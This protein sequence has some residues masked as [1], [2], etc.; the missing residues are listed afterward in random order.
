MK[1]KV[2]SMKKKKDWQTK[3]MKRKHKEHDKGILGIMFIMKHFFRHLTEW[4]EEMADPRNVSYITYSQSDY[5]YL[6]ILKNLCGVKTMHSMEEQFNEEACICTLGILS[7]NAKSTEIPHSDSLNNYLKKLSPDCLAELRKKMIKSLLRMKT[8]YGNR[9]LGKYWRIIIDGTSLYYFKEK[10]CENCLVTTRTMKNGKTL[11]LY[12]HK[13][14]EAKL[15]L[16]SKIVLSIDTEFVENESENTGK[17]D[18]E[19]NAAKRMLARLKQNYPHLPICIQ[20][21][22]LYETE[23]VIKLCKQYGF[24]YLLTHKGSRQKLLEESYRLFVENKEAGTADKIC[25]EKGKAVYV[26]HIERTVEKEYDANI[27]GYSYSEKK[28]DGEIKETKFQWIT[29]IELNAKNLE[30][31]I[32]TGRGRWKIENEGFNNQKNGIYEIEHLNSRNTTAIKNHYLLTQ[33]A[34]IIMQLYLAWN[35]MRKAVGLSIKNTS[36]MLLESFRRLQITDEDVSYCSRYT[37]V[38]LE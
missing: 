15:V 7:G 35:P 36:S 10:H 22:N 13:V 6:G 19:S 34:D 14:L 4:I 26:N 24:R 25:A 29:D 30:E 1:N 37:T 27:F 20:A 31:M 9:L 2:K 33:I 32:D 8:F 17:Q 12:C 18:C 23:P 28:D 16:S 38:Y 5:I 21:D 3:A 11:K